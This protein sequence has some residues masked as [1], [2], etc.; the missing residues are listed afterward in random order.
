MNKIQEFNQNFKYTLFLII[1]STV[2]GY[3]IFD[4]AVALSIILGGAAIMWGMS[5]LA[6]QNKKL[7]L[8]QRAN[9]VF[10]VSYL[11][12]YLLYGILL[13]LSYYLDTL[14]IFGTL[15]GLL[16]FK[17]AFYA[18]GLFKSFKGGKS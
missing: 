2:A 13:A 6:K 12:R 10:S 7:F 5:Q 1:V 16:T 3:F 4:K 11:I 8:T 9:P 17:I 18:V 14:N 15:Y